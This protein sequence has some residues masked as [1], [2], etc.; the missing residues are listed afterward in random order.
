MEARVDVK[1]RALWQDSLGRLVR[2][3][4]TVV[5]S[6]LLVLLVMAALLAP[7]ITRYSPT[8]LSPRDRLIPPNSAHWFGT[9]AFGRDVFTRVVYGGRVSLQVG[10][11]AVFISILIGVTLGLLSGYY[12]GVTES[13]IMRLIDVMLAFPGILLALVIVAILGPSLFNAMIAVGISA[14]PTYARVVRGSVLQAKELAYVEAA[15]QSGARTWR[16]ILKHILPNIL[17][18]IVVISTL[19]IANAIIAGAALSFLGLGATPPT[20]EWGL[21]LSE[22][23]NYLR[24][25]W[26]ITT[27]PGLAIMITV[28]SI[29]LIGDGLR[30]ALDP[31]MK[32]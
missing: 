30:D 5:G 4:G 32:R 11:I 26:W 14:S 7:F 8:A 2:N 24:H 13:L 21:L 3:P 31:R 28:L 12:G 17:G 29:N 6:I 16:I 15:I 25:A 18:P 27:F 19:G 22:G 20:P 10:F 9:D 1:G 23:R